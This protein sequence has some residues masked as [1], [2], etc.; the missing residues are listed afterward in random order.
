[1]VFHFGYPLLD[2]INIWTRLELLLIIV[3]V[4]VGDLVDYD[5]SFTLFLCRWRSSI[6]NENVWLDKWR[7]DFLV[8]FFRL[9]LLFLIPGVASEGGPFIEKATVKEFQ[10]CYRWKTSLISV[11]CIEYRDLHHLTFGEWIC[12]KDFDMNMAC[13]R[14]FLSRVCKNEN[15]LSSGKIGAL[16]SCHLAMIKSTIVGIEFFDFFY[17]F[18][19]TK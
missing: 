12:S 16:V 14:F 1:M 9:C 5:F 2:G 10:K 19:V 18:C 6:I 17:F 11:R 13:R 4:E 7:L 8:D 3:F 15:K